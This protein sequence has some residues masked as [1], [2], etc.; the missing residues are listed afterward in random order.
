MRTRAVILAAL[1]A[2]LALAASALAQVK[3][4]ARPARPSA[5]APLAV[6]LDPTFARIAHAR[7][8]HQRTWTAPD[9]TPE[10]IAHEIALLRPTLVT[11]LVSLAED[12]PPIDA[13]VKAYDTI[14]RIVR[15]R[16]PDCKFD[17]V[18]SAKQYDTEHALVSRMT[19]INEKFH[20]DQWFFDFLNVG[21]K[22]HPA[23]IAGAIRYAHAHHQPVGGNVFG[24]VIPDGTD[25]AAVND[26]SGFE[27]MAG[28]VRKLRRKY[29]IPVIV[30]LNNDAEKGGRDGNEQWV[31]T[32]TPEQR[33]QY[34]NQLAA[35]Q[36]ENGYRL[37]WPVLFPEFPPRHDYLAYKDG[38]VWQVLMTLLDR[39]N[40][41]P[42][43]R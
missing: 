13:Q 39:Y 7:V 9:E 30:H 19:E 25:Y 28:E 29:R 20:P 32:W 33:E 8:Y 5:P 18:L 42:A 22:A 10:T 15:E 1:V 11:G 6:D 40:A 24:T 31:R 27:K 14:R 38:G 26:G 41:A 4:W 43:V 2:S 17:F 34:L 36:Q 16:N 12:E 35:G 23:A 21:A 37:M 3:H